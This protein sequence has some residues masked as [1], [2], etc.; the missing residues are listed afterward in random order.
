MKPITPWEGNLHSTM[1]LLIWYLKIEYKN[2]SEQFT[3]H[4]V[5]INMDF[6]LHGQ[7]RKENLHSTMYLLI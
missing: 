4:Y 6:S 1:Y 2:L 3:F 7:A 5:S